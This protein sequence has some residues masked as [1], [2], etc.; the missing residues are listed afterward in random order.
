MKKRAKVL[1]VD[2]DKPLSQ[3]LLILL[4]KA[5]CE[6]Q[7]AHTGKEGL[8]LALETKFD[9]IVL[10][11][12]LPEINGLEICRELKQRHFSHRTPIVFIS[13]R[14]SNDDK[15][16][17]YQVGAVDYITKPFGVE[18]ASR[19]LIYVKRKQD[20]ADINGEAK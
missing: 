13:G 14:H 12:D 17:G 9:L 11:I 16:Q 6:A 19:L 1:V 15:R 7:A 5:G 20:V 8:R 10:D 2:D 3:M 4:A 18:I